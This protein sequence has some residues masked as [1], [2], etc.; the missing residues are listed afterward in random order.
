MRERR[1]DIPPL[2]EHF[3]LAA[4]R[5]F[6]LSAPIVSA[7]QISELMMH[8]WPGNVRE[9]QNVADR[10]VL[11]LDGDSLLQGGTQRSKSGT[12]AEQLAHFEQM[13]IADML[14]R[15]NRSIARAS[16]ELGMPKKTLYHKVRQMKIPADDARNEGLD[17]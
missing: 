2:F 4:A 1:E 16:E 11:G 14:R 3:V 15:H 8:Q 5:R 6:G 9:L 13:L 7:S 12:L 10:F 17:A